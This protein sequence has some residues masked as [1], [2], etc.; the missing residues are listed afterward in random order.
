M[1]SGSTSHLGAGFEHIFQSYFCVVPKLPPQ[2]FYCDSGGKIIHH[3]GSTCKLLS[4]CAMARIPPA[5]PV[6]AHPHPPMPEEN[7]YGKGEFCPMAA[8]RGSPVSHSIPKAQASTLNKVP[9]MYKEDVPGAAWP[10]LQPT[11]GVNVEQLDTTGCVLSF[12]AGSW[13]HSSCDEGRWSRT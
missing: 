9:G 1:H 2:Y 4:P 5:S 11:G 13:S 8:N 6:C 3:P 12:S 7:L 10:W